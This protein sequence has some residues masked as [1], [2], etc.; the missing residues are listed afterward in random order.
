VRMD[1]EEDVEPPPRDGPGLDEWVAEAISEA[2]LMKIAPRLYPGE[3]FALG[4][5]GLAYT[6]RNGEVWCGRSR[7]DSRLGW[8]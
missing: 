4:A 7:Q 3:T 1:T 6:V 8:A 5:N 2:L